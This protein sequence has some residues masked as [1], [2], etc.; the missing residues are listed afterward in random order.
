MTE[1]DG[2]THKEEVKYLGYKT[3]VSL[4]AETGIVTSIKPTIG[5]SALNKQMPDLIRHDAK[6]GVPAGTY[7]GDKGYD[8]GELHT[9]LWHLGEHSALR[10]LTSGQPR[11]MTARRSGSGS[12]PTPSTRQG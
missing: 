5:E 1:P 10:L 4:D 2:T 6:M 3:H 7:A 12:W 11:K 8:D 9:L